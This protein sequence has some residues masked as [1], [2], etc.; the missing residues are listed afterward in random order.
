MYS[1]LP[2]H[3]VGKPIHIVKLIF[4]LFLI[5]IQQISGAQPARLADPNLT[6]SERYLLMKTKAQ[7]YGDYK[8]VKETDLDA[9]Y[10]IMRDSLQTTRVSLSNSNKSIFTLHGQ[11]DS[12]ESAIR[13]KETYVQTIIYDSTHISVLGMNLQKAFYKGLVGILMAIMIIA[14]I[15]II[16]RM[17][18]MQRALKEKSDLAEETAVAYAEYK[19]QAMEKQTRLAR[20]LQTELNKPGR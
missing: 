14:L 7:T 9:V 12:L 2:L 19:R 5:F 8:A 3:E 13:L 10:Q 17:R 20:E 11:V 16:G 18:L 6:L 1:Y 4:L 15:I